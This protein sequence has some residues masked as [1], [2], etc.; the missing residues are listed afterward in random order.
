MATRPTGGSAW[1]LTR[2]PL[3]AR[4]ARRLGA[5]PR[6]VRHGGGARAGRDRVPRASWRVF[7]TGVLARGRAGAGQL[8]RAPGPATGA[9]LPEKARE[10][11]VRR[12]HPGGLGAGAGA[13]RLLRVP[14]VPLAPASPDP[15]GSRTAAGLY[16]TTRQTR[17]PKAPG[18]EFAPTSSR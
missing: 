3:Q 2:E 18:G 6:Q 16:Y 12:V 11:G 9:T 7:G 13:S 17:P 1:R 14:L 5:E 15:W 4:R 10:F 8:Q